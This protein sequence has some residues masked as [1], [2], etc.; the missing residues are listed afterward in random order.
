MS[1]VTTNG[2]DLCFEEAGAGV[3]ILLIPPAGTMA[4]TGAPL[5]RGRR[6]PARAGRA[7]V[8]DSGHAATLKTRPG[9][10]AT[11]RRSRDPTAPPPWR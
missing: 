9:R 11:V 2:C 1:R 5:A 7:D 6:R 3:P 8:P 4:A 10:L